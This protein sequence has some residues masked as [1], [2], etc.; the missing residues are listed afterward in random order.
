[1]IPP[2]TATIVVRHPCRPAVS[3]LF[4]GELEPHAGC[5]RPIHLIRSGKDHVRILSVDTN[6]DFLTGTINES[7]DTLNVHVVAPQQPGRFDGTLTLNFADATVPTT[8]VEV[9]GIVR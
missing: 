9:A 6:R 7:H 2:V 1:M 3:R 4:F 5:D 8:T